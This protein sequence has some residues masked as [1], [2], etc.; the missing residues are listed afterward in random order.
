MSDMLQLVVELPNTQH[1]R[2]YIYGVKRLV[3]ARFQ[4]SCV[5]GITTTS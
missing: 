1:H 5:V 2:N 4:L 3:V